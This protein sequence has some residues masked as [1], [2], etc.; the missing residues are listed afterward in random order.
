MQ[1]RSERGV[2]ALALGVV[3]QGAEH[4]RHAV[5]VG[6]PVA[7]HR[8]Q[9]LAGVEFGHQGEAGADPER[10]VHPHRLAEGVEEG[11]GAEDD[12]ARGDL[13]G[14]AGGDVGVAEEVGWVSSAPFG[15]PV[16]PEV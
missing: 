16:V 13:A 4:R 10:G 14:R 8:R 7:L 5:E 1:L 15:L 9:R 12:V 2:V 3:E 6:D 11:Q